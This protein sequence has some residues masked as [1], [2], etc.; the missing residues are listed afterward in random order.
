MVLERYQMRLGGEAV[1]ERYAFR[2]EAKDGSTIWVEGGAVPIEWEGR[3]AT[4]NFLSDVTERKRAEDALHDLNQ[5]LQLMSKLTRYDILNQITVMRSCLEREADGQDPL[6][7]KELQRKALLATRN[8]EYMI[9]F[10][11]DY[12][13]IGINEPIWHDVHALVDGLGPDLS[14]QGIRLENLLPEVNVLADPMLVKVMQNLVDNT[15]RHGLHAKFVRFS[16]V[17]NGEVLK[18]MCEDDGVGVPVYEKGRIFERGYGKHPGL[19]LHY[20]REVL[21][22]TGIDIKEKG[23]PGK[24]ANFVILVPRECWRYPDEAATGNASATS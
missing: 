11:R 15:V 12:Q 4:L 22:M 6:K 14:S 24:G 7:A 10:S 19:G 5:K 16:S 8:M 3:R 1:P 23:E 2:L 18:I 13:E 9:Q 17:T 21:H 20:A